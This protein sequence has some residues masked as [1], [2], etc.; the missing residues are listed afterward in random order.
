M[1]TRIILADDHGIIRQGLRSLINRQQSM[2]VVAEAED[3]RQ[4]V[5]L[6]LELKPTLVV[7]DVS[8]PNLNGVEATR[9]ILRQ[10]P[11]VRVVALSMHA[12]REYVDRMLEAGACGYMLK[13]CAFEELIEAIRTVLAGRLFLSRRAADAVAGGPRLDRQPVA[14]AVDLTPRER[15][16]LQL[17]SEGKS[18]KD[19]ATALRVSVK[20]VETHRHNIMEKLSIHTVAE[21]N[22]VRH[23]ARHNG[24]GVKR[25][26]VTLRDS[27]TRARKLPDCTGDTVLYPGKVGVTAWGLAD[28]RRS[29]ARGDGR[30]QQRRRPC[31]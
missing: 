17:I 8:M 20:T 4:A 9:Q 2:E 29:T 22:E 5:Q 27:P 6:A 11:D 12:D 16:V 15:E 3:G 31:R 28:E 13:D 19:T 7:M 30:R 18:T 23:P 21:L 14:A 1:K 24:L 10:D 25:S 26:E